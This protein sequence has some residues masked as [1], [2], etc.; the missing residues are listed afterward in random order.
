MKKVK[1]PHKILA[2]NKQIQEFHTTVSDVLSKK[3]AQYPEVLTPET[4]QLVARQSDSP[5]YNHISSLN[6]NSMS[7]DS[8][9]RELEQSAPT[10]QILP[11][12][13]QPWQ[14]SSS[15]D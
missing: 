14:G 2:L 11:T 7:I 12:T 8:P 3:E 1:Y 10:V 9:Y 6:S 4:K 13:P 5:Y 15:L